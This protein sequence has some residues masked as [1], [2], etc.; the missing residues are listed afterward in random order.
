LVEFDE[1]GFD[2][3][4]D[5]EADDDEALA[6]LGGA[7]D[8]FDAR[9]FPEEFLHG[10]GGAF[11]DFAGAG[12]GHGDEDVDHGDFD[13]GFLFAREHEDSADAEEDGG[14][15]DEGSEFG[16][17]EGVGETAGDAE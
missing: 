9:D 2:V 12:A 7:V 14:E 6:G 10:A 5:F 4:A 16:I 3:F 17:D 11:F 1:A 8:V 15:D 13:L